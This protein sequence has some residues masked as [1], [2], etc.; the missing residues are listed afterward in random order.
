MLLLKGDGFQE[1]VHVP[2]SGEV[3][4]GG[5]LRGE[6]NDVVLG[7]SKGRGFPSVRQDYTNE[8]KNQGVTSQVANAYFDEMLKWANDEQA[9]ENLLE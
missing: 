7:G 6:V 8:M 5:A 2:L 3:G 1:G 4:N 9:N